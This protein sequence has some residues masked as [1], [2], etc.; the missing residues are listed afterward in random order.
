M[1]TATLALML[2]AWSG[3][4]WGHDHNRPDLNDWF[5]GLHSKGNSPCC[6]GS[7]ATALDDPDWEVIEYAGEKPKYRVRIEGN[8]IDVPDSAV[9]DAP[10]KDGRAMVWPYYINGEMRGIRC[11]MPGSMS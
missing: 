9:V 6:D 2:V 5:M 10:N 3:V 4:A 11:F 1:K 7:D 8:W